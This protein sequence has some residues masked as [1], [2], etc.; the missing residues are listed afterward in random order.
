MAVI[1]FTSASGAPGVSTTAL[2]LAMSWPRP[3]LLVEADP[4]GGAGILAGFLR[5]TTQYE[6]GLIELRLSPLNIEDALRD[7]VRTLTPTVSYVCG[8]RTHAQAGALRDL[9]EPLGAMLAGLDANGQDVLVDAGRLGLI[10]TPQPLLDHSDLTLLVARTSLPALAA[11]RS[12]AATARD[13]TTGWQAAGAL[14][15]GAGQPYGVREVAKVLGLQV[16]ADLPDDPASAA[17]YHQGA[18]PPR[19]FETGRYYR[20]VTAAIESIQAQVARGRFEL[21]RDQRHE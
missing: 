2:A 5:G 21:I 16:I 15:I 11:A 9:W 17:V 8:V 12:W 18:P 13:R 6:A 3:V 7:V 10:G 14:L 20:A 19:R 4:S 1:T